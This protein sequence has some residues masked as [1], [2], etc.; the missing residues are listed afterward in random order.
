MK[1]LLISISSA[2][3]INALQSPHLMATEQIETVD[4]LPTTYREPIATTEPADI[5][6]IHI[7]YR[8]AYR[9]DVA[10]HDLPQSITVLGQSLITDAGLTKFQDLLD[11]SA[12]VSRQN[13]SGG[14]WDSFAIRGFPG[15]ENIPSG[16]LIN[17]FNGG[18]GFSGN[19]DLSNVAYVE[20]LKGP[21]SALYGRSEPGGT[22]NIITKKPQYQTSGY[23][24]GSSASE[25]QYRLEADFTTGIMDNIAVRVNGAWQDYDSFRDNVFDRKKTVTPSIRWQISDKSSLLYEVEYLKQEK[26]FDRGVVVIDNNINTLPRS[27]YL[28]EPNDGANTIDALGHQLSY[29]YQLSDDW[30]LLAGYNYRESSLQG[31]SSDAEL[32]MSRQSLFDDN[33]TLTRQHRYRDYDSQDHSVRLELS[34]RVDT[35]SLSH[36]L[37]MGAD[38]YDY[39]LNTAFYRYRGNSGSYAIDIFQPVYGVAFPEVNL[40][41]KNQEKQRAWGG[42]IQDQIDLTDRWKLQLGLRFD[43]YKQN[44]IEL[45]SQASSKQSDNRTSPKI[46]LVY[47]YSDNLS[48]YSVYSEGFLPMSGTDYAGTPFEPEESQSIEVGLKFNSYWHN[49]LAIDANIAFFDAKKNNILTSDPVNIGFSAALG[50]AKSSGIE[51]DLS[52]DISDTLQAKLSYA[53]LNTRTSND[54]INADWGVLVPAGSALVNVPKNTGSIML[55]QSLSPLS[56]EGSTGVSWHYVDSR[57]GD[58]VNP[59]FQL[60]SYQLFGLFFNTQLTNQINVAVNINNLLDKHYIAQSYS[61]LW[62]AP[63]EPRN[64][65]M[66]ISYEF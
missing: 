52:A 30:S 21:G 18:R 32:A 34:G 58:S 14:L 12:S 4:Q 38:A 56:L 29:D 44:I 45:V 27:R 33:Q 6:R 28:G 17:G 62:A 8:Q 31:Y 54:S 15:N 49:D 35:G 20:V 22:V 65:K 39:H 13:N 16:Y 60:P 23:I 55:T 10:T 5:E 43:Y 36:H 40:L 42:Y 3:I 61:A 46:G 19:R 50:E 37:L 25:N 66:S 11:F 63:G 47:A 7:H 64:I 48:V 41:Y 57:L 26:L 24:K 1:A 51:I 2:L 53:Y 9:G 59:D